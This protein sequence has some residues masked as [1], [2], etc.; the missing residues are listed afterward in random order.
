M[1]VVNAEFFLAEGFLCSLRKG[2]V[3]LVLQ[4]H[5]WAEGWLEAGNYLE[6]FQRKLAGHVENFTARRADRIIATSRFVRRWLVEK[7]H[8][9]QERVWIIHEPI[10]TARYRPV[11]SSMRERL[12]LP[13]DVPLVLFVSALEPRKG[14]YVFAQAIPLVL[15]QVPEAKFVV[16][17]RDTNM[18]PGR[19]S[20]KAC[21]QG[22]ADKGGFAEK[23]TFTD[24]ADDIVQAYSACDILVSAGLLEA[25]GMPPIEA[26]ACNRPVVA[27]ATGIAAELDGVSPAIA[28]VPLADPQALAQAIVQLLSLSKGERER[29][30]AGHRRIVEE[31]FSFERA[32]N[33]TLA[34][35]EGAI[36]ERHQQ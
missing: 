14:P 19:G 24:P 36:A 13:R 9:P 31:R 27:T 22:L 34:V 10:D 21:M 26:M 7:V 11:K 5:A 32:V 8:I 35:Y 30:A 6:S 33:E 29:L 20:M 17:G 12:H 4:L 23:L 15:R 18:A 25:A 1:D 3:P 16:A 2:G 28:I